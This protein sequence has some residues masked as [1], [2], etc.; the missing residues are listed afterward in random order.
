M[1][2]VPHSMVAAN[3]ENVSAKRGELIEHIKS[4]R[5]K[6]ISSVTENEWENEKDDKHSAPP[7][8]FNWESD[9]E[10]HKRGK[11][12]PN[13]VTGSQNDDSNVNLKSKC[14]M[15]DA[16]DDTHAADY[17]DNTHTADDTDNTHTVNTTDNTHTV[18]AT[19][20][21]YAADATDNAH[22]ADATHASDAFEQVKQGA[23]ET[24]KKN[25]EKPQGE[26][27]KEDKNEVEG[28]E[29]EQEE[30]EEEEQEEEEEEENDQ[31]KSLEDHEHDDEQEIEESY[32]H[33]LNREEEEKKIVD[34][35]NY[36]M[37]QQGFQ[38]KQFIM[39]RTK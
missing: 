7:G 9:D 32:G 22:A 28:K 13:S 38:G 3:P 6:N 27:N 21:A 30:E 2:D 31:N 29:E 14:V 18:D 10:E 23:E 37:F 15:N 8:N 36:E 24:Q 1:Q 26:V 33:L 19:D 5:S 20:N 12:R 25:E 34:L 17:T 39:V 16:A 11:K 4:Q 35:K